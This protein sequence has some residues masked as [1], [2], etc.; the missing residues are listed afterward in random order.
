[1]LYDELG[2]RLPVV[3]IPCQSFPDDHYKVLFVAEDA[4]DE[5]LKA[6]RK[7]L[8]HPKGSA[9]AAQA[10]AALEHL[11]DPARRVEYDGQRA[12]SIKR[13]GGFDLSGGSD[14]LKQV[15]LRVSSSSD[16]SDRSGSWSQV[17]PGLRL[18]ADG[19]SGARSGSSARLTA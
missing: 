9:E 12:R 11:L 6:A 10:D 14:L 16:L 5:V 7:A 15:R 2:S 1:M 13:G 3:L 18:P 8:K 19:S 17:S 4:P